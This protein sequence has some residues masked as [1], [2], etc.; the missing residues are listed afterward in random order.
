MLFKYLWYRV[1][2]FVPGKMKFYHVADHANYNH[3]VTKAKC[4]ATTAHKF[5][6]NAYSIIE[7]MNYDEVKRREFY[8][9]R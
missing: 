5:D 6:S 3:A 7:V 4:A 9:R 2:I 1:E 8:G